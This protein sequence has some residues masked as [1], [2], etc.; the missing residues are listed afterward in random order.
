MALASP[1]LYPMGNYTPEGIASSEV[2]I[3]WLSCPW[4]SS[5]SATLENV[6][7]ADSSPRGLKQGLAQ[8]HP[9]EG[10][11]GEGIGQDLGFAGC[12]G[13]SRT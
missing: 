7:A 1:F 8:Q 10:E 3:S 11:A 5:Q 12:G 2:N 9:F 4:G 6:L 13:W